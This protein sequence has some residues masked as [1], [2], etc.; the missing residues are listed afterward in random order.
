M[1]IE[2]PFKQGMA[3]SW[4]ALLLIFTWFAPGIEASD[5]A[6][7]YVG[8]DQCRQCHSD[9]YASWNRSDHGKAMRPATDANVLGDFGNVSVTFHGI[10]TRLFRDG[11]KF[12]VETAGAGGK[13]AT[14]DIAYT[15]GHYPL[16]QYLVDTGNGHLQALNVAWDSRAADLGGQRWYH[17]QADEEIDPG[18]PFFWTRHFQ[19]ANSRC[20]ECHAT[21]YNKNFDPETR[22]YASAW[23]ET[24][25]GCEAC[26]GPASRHVELAQSDG[27][28][29]ADSGFDNKPAAGLRWAL[30]EGSPIAAPAGERDDSYIDTCGACHSRRSASGDMEHLAPFHDR[31]RLATIDPG[32]Y[33]DDGQIDDEVF[34]LGS[35]LQSKMAQRGVTCG[36][37][38]DPHSGKTVADGNALCAR[39]HLPAVYDSEKHHRHEPGANGAACVDCHMPERV[40]MT[41]DPRRDHSFPI[42]D[43]AFSQKSGAPNACNLC[44]DDKTPAWAAE[45]MRDWGLDAR[46]NRWASINHGLNLQDSKAFLDYVRNPPAGLAPIR[47]ASL[48][49]KTGV[50]PSQFAYQ[51]AAA[52]LAS[53]EPLLRRA[54]VEMLESAPL[55][56]RW[57]LLQPLI[58]DPLQSVRHAVAIAL[59][60]VLP[61]LT[62]KDAQ[63]LQR[64]LDARRVAL[65]Y[66][67]D[68]PAGQLAIGNF[69][70]RTGFPILAEQAFKAAL[71][72]EPRFVPAL[73]N[74]ADLYRGIGAD[75]EALE[76]LQRALEFAPDSANSNHAYG[77]YLVRAGKRDEALPYLESAAR[78]SDSSPRHVY[79]YAVALDSLGQTGKA[80]ET[81]DAASRR[82]PNQ[83]DL[84]FLQVAY[85]DKTAQTDGIHQYLSVL[86]AFAANIPQVQAWIAKYGGG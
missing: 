85:M 26:H 4:I 55:E 41:V 79:V 84:S 27:L 30:A 53:P 12:R 86:E 9:L 7:G 77:L 54:A 64:L 36:N 61:Q 82:W 39:C 2:Y 22:V 45:A 75:R 1:D 33:F 29:D 72:I 24:G 38:H 49:G 83:L 10:E 57:Q 14:W 5:S 25:V 35:F 60:D 17:L 31:Y 62:G 43:P 42:P 69:E 80:I 13:T 58:D 63:R 46:N 32:L 34:V 51:R 19:N 6:Q 68:S 66:H 37:C 44:H 21:D 52:L 67:A 50:F 8:S 18:H 71:E 81:I 16:Q 65:A 11:A 76:L 56:L 48:I 73:L 47:E 28:G 59:A 23:S 15:F 74:L 40:Y 3:R 78:Q 20:I 70:L